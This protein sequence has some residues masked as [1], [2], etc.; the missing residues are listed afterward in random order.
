MSS[1]SNQEPAGKP[2]P[3]NETTMAAAAA[4]WVENIPIPETPLSPFREVFTYGLPPTSYVG[5]ANQPPYATSPIPITNMS[6]A[7]AQEAE[8]SPDPEAEPKSP[9]GHPLPPV[10]EYQP[11]PAR[12]SL[13]SV[14]AKRRAAE[15][16]QSITSTMAGRQPP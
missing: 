15:C 7:I 5:A 10:P 12:I 4:E 8:G 1:I 11:R 6:D 16:H 3:R 13:R 14:L 9:G 2:Q